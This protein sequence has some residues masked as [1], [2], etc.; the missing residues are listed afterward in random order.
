MGDLETYLDHLVPTTRDDDW[1]LWVGREANAGN[2]LGVALVGDGVLAVTEGVPELDRPVTG[3][4][5]NLPVVGGERDGK[6]IVGVADEASGGLAGGEFPE[7]EGLV[8]GS[9]ESVGAVG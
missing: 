5:N 6:N 1:V 2:P 8:P 3:A 9:G 4:G 7:T